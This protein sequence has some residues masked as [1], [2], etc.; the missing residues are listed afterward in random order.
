MVAFYSPGFYRVHPAFN[1]GSKELQ[2][3]GCENGFLK[4]KCA[5]SYFVKM[6]S[7]KKED[8]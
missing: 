6:I 3:R 2:I 5:Y 7:L 4:G 8:A 1:F